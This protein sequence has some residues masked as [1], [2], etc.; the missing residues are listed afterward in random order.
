MQSNLCNVN[1]QKLYWER[2]LKTQHKILLLVGKAQAHAVLLEIILEQDCRVIK[3]LTGVPNQ[4][5]I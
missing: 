1:A 3:V 4:T 5:E 2:V